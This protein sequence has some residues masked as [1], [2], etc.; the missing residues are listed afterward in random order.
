[1]A[2]AFSIIFYPQLH[3]PALRP[4]F[5]FGRAYGLTTFR[6]HTYEWVRVCLSAGGFVYLRVGKGKPVQPA[7]YLLVQAFQRIWL[8]G[9]H[10]VYQQFTSV[11]HTTLILAPVPPCAGSG[12]LASRLGCYSFEFSYI[13]PEAIARMDYSFPT[14]W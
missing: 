10:D 14:F 3:Q 8:V 13:V 7:T 2:F 4:A 9:S 6:L 12:N 5:P 1:M 11:T